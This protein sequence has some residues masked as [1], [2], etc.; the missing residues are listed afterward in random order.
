MIEQWGSAITT[1]SGNGAPITFYIAF[2]N[3][4]YFGIGSST[5]KNEYT[6]ARYAMTDRTTTGCYMWLNNINNTIAYWLT[7][8]Y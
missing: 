7:K 2:S 4:D 8:G 3:T 5:A 6:N 1:S